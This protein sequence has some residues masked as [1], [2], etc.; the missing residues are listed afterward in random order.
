MIKKYLIVSLLIEI[1][2]VSNAAIKYVPTDFSSIQS[3]I[4]HSQNGDTIILK[5]GKYNENVNFLGKN[6]VLASM[7]LLTNDTAFITKTIIDGQ[8]NESV[9][10]IVNNENNS[11]QICGL[12]I[13]NGK[14][15]RGGGICIDT[16]SKPLI[17]N[18]KIYR[19]SANGGGGVSIGG[20]S[21][22]ILQYCKIFDNQAIGDLV[23]GGGISL[24]G[25]SNTT[26]CYC[27]I[28]NNHSD[29]WGGGI[30]SIANPRAT[31][32]RFSASIE[33]CVIYGNSAGQGG[34]GISCWRGCNTK[35]TNSTICNNISET[36]P[37]LDIY[38]AN[39]TL[40]NSIVYNDI[41]L[42]N[43]SIYFEKPNCCTLSFSNELFIDRSLIYGGETSVNVVGGQANFYYQD[44]NIE[45]DP[46]FVDRKNNNYHLSQNSPCIDKGTPWF[47]ILSDTIESGFVLIGD[48][49]H[50]ATKEHGFIAIGDTLVNLNSN[51]Y[52]GKL[53]DMGA[54][55]FLEPNSTEK[56]E[57]EDIK[58]FP[59]PALESISIL[60]PNGKLSRIEVY[61]SGGQVMK[62]EEIN[63]NT[64]I[65]DL[66][67]LQPG[68][69]LLKLYTSNKIETRKILKQ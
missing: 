1:G 44:G 51:E 3:A 5:T 4:N 45:S 43:P 37:E 10:K 67:D 28:Y 59:N 41:D 36:Y 20:N 47:N 49:F 61:H 64:C 57:L 7:Y 31:L 46:L 56:K 16:N 26:I 2:L 68:V 58:I 22:P 55:E 33:R 39:V 18:C 63:E 35:I 52:L 30:Y 12:S 53:P 27:E 25:F 29:Y 21:C 17:R 40:I 50:Q 62:S 60:S 65:I 13:T 24:G 66:S 6:I 34:G 19:N 32:H 42:N 69:Y 11:T 54:F 48:I 14:S 9:I 15:T 38:D 23:N 8:G